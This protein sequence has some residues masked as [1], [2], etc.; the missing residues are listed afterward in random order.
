M[1]FTNRQLSIENYSVRCIIRH[2]TCCIALLVGPVFVISGPLASEQNVATSK[3][4]WQQTSNESVFNV[5]LDPQ[6]NDSVEINQF[7]EWVVTI[8]TTDGKA[9][10]PARVV[11]T[12]GMPMHGHGLPS[13]P[14]LSEYLGEGKYLL[15][16]LLF[17]MYGRWNIEL[18]IQSASMRDQVKFEIKLDY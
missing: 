12:G 2:W 14:Q 3:L 16:G 13:Q 9:V 1:R 8:K 5:T 4:L 18:D 7:L 11:V 17:S 6:T 15:K 10:S